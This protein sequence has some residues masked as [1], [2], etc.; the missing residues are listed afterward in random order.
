MDQTEVDGPGGHRGPHVL[1]QRLWGGIRQQ[2]KLLGLFE[3]DPQHEFYSLTCMMREGLS[4]A[5]QSTIDHPIPGQVA[6]WKVVV[7]PRG[8]R[9]TSP[10]PWTQR[11]YGTTRRL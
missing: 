9:K 8:G 7:M 2:W 4:A 11:Y 10:F 5:I 3:I 6:A 1:K